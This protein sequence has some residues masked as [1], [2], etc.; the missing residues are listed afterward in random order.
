M[1]FS[2]AFV[3]TACVTLLLFALTLGN[4]CSVLVSG[5]NSSNMTAAE[6]TGD[7]H[8]LLGNRN[9][10]SE[11]NGWQGVYAPE[12]ILAQSLSA[13]FLS[14][15]AFIL[16]LLFIHRATPLWRLYRFAYSHWLVGVG[17]LPVLLIVHAA[18]AY[19]A[20]LENRVN[21]SGSLTA[22]SVQ[23]SLGDVPVYVWVIGVV[24]LCALVPMVEVMR[25]HD[26]KLLAKSQRF[27]RLEFETKLGMN[28]PF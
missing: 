12:L 15:C 24:W 6:L 21:A 14:L 17:L 3:P 26:R 4:F 8:P 9:E 27:L 22:S 1:Y 19:I 23:P 5:R 20:A 18:A 11:W 28:S 7:C 10:S 2:I 25:H 13:I 16:A